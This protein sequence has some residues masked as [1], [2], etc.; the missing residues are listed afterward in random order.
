[1]SGT[2]SVCNWDDFQ[3]YRDRDP[4]WIKLYRDILTAETWL[5]GTDHTRLIQVAITLLAA[6]YKNAIPNRPDLIRK[7]AHLDVSEKDITKALKHLSDFGFIKINDL[8][9]SEQDASTLLAKCSSEAEAEGET[10]AEQRE[11]KTGVVERI[12]AHWQNTHGKQRAALDDKRRKIIS[13]AL[14]HY[15]EATLCQA[16]TGILNSPHHMG[17]ND[18]QTKYVDIEH[19]IGSTKRVDHSVECYERGPIAKLTQKQLQ[20]RQVGADWLPPE[21]RK[22]AE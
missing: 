20:N 3:H 10:E 9:T 7:A 6:R 2:I 22:N 1:M 14:K 15:D 5:L 17:E 19:C 16:I 4:P 21:D 13:N 18:R 11:T 12:F 8:L